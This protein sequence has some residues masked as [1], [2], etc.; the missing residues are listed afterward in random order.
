MA[1]QY[2]L[3]L[4][5]FEG[6]LDL[7]LHLVR[8]NELSIFKID[9]YKLTSQYL[10][11]LRLMKFTDM[12]ESAAFIEMAADLIEI[13]SRRLLA[14]DNKEQ[15]G[16]SIDAEDAEQKFKQRLKMYELFQGA[17]GF[18][19]GLMNNSQQTYTNYEYK[20][21]QSKSQDK[22]V[23][24]KGDT[25][26]LLVLYEQ[27][28]ARL[29]EKREQ[30]VSVMTEGMPLDEV[31]DKILVKLREIDVVFFEKLYAKISSRYELVA[32]IMGMLQIVRDGKAKLY[33]DQHLGPLWLYSNMINEKKF[34]EKLGEDG[35][36]K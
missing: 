5:R 22:Q 27:L 8:F 25:T 12:Q 31:I 14:E 17:G 28:L 13:K 26:T 11:H 1:T 35:F 9:L 36:I 16:L 2:Y 33:Q 3:K 30:R 18:F 15:E 32:N 4:D 6:P 23:P 10:E 7:L 24:I 21:W 34:I 19:S 29:G 20:V